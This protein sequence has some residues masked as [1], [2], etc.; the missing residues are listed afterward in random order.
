MTANDIKYIP[1][2]HQ[3][4][5]SYDLTYFQ[6]DIV[7]LYVF[8]FSVTDIV[9]HTQR[10]PTLIRNSLQFACLELNCDSIEQLRSKVMS[11][12]AETIN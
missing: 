2:L 1:F 4:F 7:L 3:I 8:G 11:D 6:Q 12:L 10:S 5:T 9:D